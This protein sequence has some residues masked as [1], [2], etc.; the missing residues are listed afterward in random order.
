MSEN[1]KTDKQTPSTSYTLEEGRGNLFKASPETK[2]TDKHPDYFGKVNVN[3]EVMMLSGWMRESQAGN[4]YISLNVK[5]KWEKEE[6]ENNVKT[7]LP[8]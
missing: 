6:G 1:V 5:P 4:N 8:F 7:D 3:G 2:K